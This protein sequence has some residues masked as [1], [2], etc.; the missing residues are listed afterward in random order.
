VAEAAKA[1]RSILVQV[2]C[3][4]SE[5]THIHAVTACICKR[6][7]QSVVVG[8]TTVGEIVHGRLLSN[9]TIIGFT[10][11]GSSGLRAIALPCEQGGEDRVRA[12]LGRRIAECSTRVAGV[13]L[14]A[15]TVSIDPVSLLAG[16]NS[17]ALGLPVFG[18]GAADYLGME[19]S[20]VFTGTE[21]FSHGALV[22]A[23]TGEDLHVEAQTYLGWRPLSKP[24]RIT[25]VEGLQVKRIDGAPAFDIYK[26]G[27]LLPWRGPGQ[28]TGPCGHSSL[29]G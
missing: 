18:G 12:E 20:L 22:V 4:N 10:F 26:R 16:L 23:L 27:C 25:E 29:S 28:A 1:A 8:A 2:Y 9:K 6:L 19:N 24:M 17:V 15:T 13:L 21:L 11:F 3:A 14:L 7:P 5:P